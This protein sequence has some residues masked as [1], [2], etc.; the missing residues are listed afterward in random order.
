M[1]LLGFLKRDKHPALDER[2]LGRWQLLKAEG[3]MDVGEGVTMTFT[4]D[5]N[6]VYVIHQKDSKQIMNLSY[7]VEG[8]RLVTNQPSQPRDES[9]TYSFDAEGNLILEY[10]GSKAWLA[11]A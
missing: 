5:G 8:G 3:D 6:L 11:P 4:S 9:T 1:G 2:L 7:R 10:V